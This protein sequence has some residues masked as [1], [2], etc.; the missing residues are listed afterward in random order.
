MV[1]TLGVAHTL[2]ERR[3]LHRGEARTRETLTLETPAERHLGRATGFEGPA[4]FD[5]PHEAQPMRQPRPRVTFALIPGG[6]GLQP[7]QM[8]PRAPASTGR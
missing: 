8:G 4:Q 6:V 5:G 7:A 1:H 3:K 2:R